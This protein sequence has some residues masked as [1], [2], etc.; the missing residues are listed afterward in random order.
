[1]SVQENNSANPTLTLPPLTLAATSGGQADLGA[2]GQPVVLY[3]YP[4]DSTPGC[5][6]EAQDFR[7]QHAEFAALGYVVLGVSRDSLRS[8]ENFKCKQELP[9]ELLSDPDEA[10][11]NALGVMKLK[12]MYGKQVRG[13]ERST[14]IFAADGQLLREWR[15]VKVPNHVAEVLQFL[16]GVAA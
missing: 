4:K 8:H 1:M 12:T 13:I 14:F 15:G 11:C 7:D 5:T 16:R 9:F 6:I 10:L 3:F 2:L